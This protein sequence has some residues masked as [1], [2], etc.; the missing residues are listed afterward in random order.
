MCVNTRYFSFLS[1]YIQKWFKNVFFKI[2]L[3]LEKNPLLFMIIGFLISAGGASGFINFYLETRFLYLVVPRTSNIWTQYQNI[4]DK[5]GSPTATMSL[6]IS[7]ENKN[8]NNNILTPN[9]MNDIYDIYQ[10][11]YFTH[12][13]TDLFNDIE[14]SEV[15]L[16][17]YPSSS[18]CISDYTNIFGEIFSNQE[19]LWNDQQ[20]L[21]NEINDNP[22]TD[23]FVGGI[24]YNEDSNLITGGTMINFIYELK[25]YNSD[26]NHIVY[27]YMKYWNEYW[28]KYSND[29]IKRNGL[30]INYV[31]DRSL[32][33]EI[34]RVI[35]GDISIFGLAFGL[36]MLYFIFALGKL[37]CI[38]TRM[39]L[40]FSIG[41]VLLC[42]IICGFGIGL[43][44]GGELS[45]VVMLIP[46]VLLG[47]GVDDM[48]IITKSYD[49]SKKYHTKNIIAYALQQS[50]LAIT[51]TSLCSCTALFIGAIIPGIPPAITTFCL[52]GGFAFFTNY[53]MQFLIFVPLLLFDEQRK[54]RK[55]NFACFCLTYDDV[56]VDDD[57]KNKQNDDGKEKKFDF[58]CCTSPDV[59]CG[60]LMS[61]IMKYRIIRWIIIFIFFGCAIYCILV[62]PEIDTKSDL[63]LLVPDDSSIIGYYDE[64]DIG[65]NE[66]TLI[67]LEIVIED[68]DFSNIADRYSILKFINDLEDETQFIAQNNWLQSYIDWLQLQYNINVN[69]LNS[70][71]FYK[72]LQLFANND[73]ANYGDIV[74]KRNY[75]GNITE[76]EA[77]RFY[78]FAF[79]DSDAA[80][81]WNE[82]KEWN[83]IMN[84]YG[85]NGYVFTSNYGFSYVSSE[86]TQLIIESMFYSA[87]GVF[88]VILIFSDT[89]MA[90]FILL[91]V[92][93]IDIDLIGCLYFFNFSLNIITYSILVMAVGLTVDYVIHIV[94]AIT[95]AKETL[96]NKNK[97]NPINFDKILELGM[98]TM[99]L[100]VLKGAFTSL[101]GGLPL[102]ISNSEGFRIFGAMWISII[103]IA[104][105]HGFFFVPAILYEVYNFYLSIYHPNP[106]ENKPV[107]VTMNTLE[108]MEKHI[109]VESNEHDEYNGHNNYDE[110]DIMQINE[111]QDE[112]FIDD[113]KERY[114]ENKEKE[115][116]ANVENNNIIEEDEDKDNYDNDDNQIQDDRQEE[117]NN[118]DNYNPLLP[119]QEEEEEEEEEDNYN[120]TA[121]RTTDILNQIPDIGNK[122][123]SVD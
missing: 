47:V 17:L 85:I 71:D 104:T 75:F 70:N 18:D 59:F 68:T 87:I 64:F 19:Q 49:Y 69:T 48:I 78:V 74:Y 53:V 93:L 83:N 61:G 7:L 4:I 39:W 123:K 54:E 42:A 65:F 113:M 91:V 6:L 63:T 38:N 52:L 26:T 9:N 120:E 60:K 51:Q 116:V 34:L 56:D 14:Y 62:I 22:S 31:N 3:R 122:H 57:D 20:L 115:D 82:Y 94:H 73:T 37:D 101:L 99:G 80:T 118:D 27:Q 23:L 29:Y 90:L 44:L 96:Q 21:L 13:E 36:M 100:S 15:C 102:L 41:I 98:R 92:L 79:S 103:L 46:Y 89:R 2:G 106:V 28:E 16:T 24:Q 30:K 58:K 43:W 32:D 66:Q 50:G 25:S 112:Q 12:N 10:S 111:K 1:N 5:F 8:N 95:E 110:V 40:A 33:D 114:Q 109:P 77:T 107:F 105:L 121:P 117:N 76:I 97:N 108:M 81:Q 55:A 67:E 119:R 88:I 86:I 45:L 11:I 84:K 35:I 72:Y